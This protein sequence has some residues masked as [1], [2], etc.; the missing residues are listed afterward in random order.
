[1]A[2]STWIKTTK[3]RSYHVRIPEK[4]LTKD[5]SKLRLGMRN[6]GSSYQKWKLRATRVLERYGNRN[7]ADLWWN[8]LNHRQQKA[9]L[10][11]YPN[12]EVAK[13]QY[14]HMSRLK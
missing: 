7:N 12:K 6:I 3:G 9:L 13:Q 2:L 8:K 14:L 1:M 5:K 4:Y 11:R 10:A